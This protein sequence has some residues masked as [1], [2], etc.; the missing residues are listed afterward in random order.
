MRRFDGEDLLYFYDD[1]GWLTS[2]R[3]SWTDTAE[4][5]PFLE[6][7]GGRACFRVDHLLALASLVE[8]ARE[9]EASDQPRKA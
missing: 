5:H 8:G 2:V 1:A 7:A 4:S 9:A 6:L 3:R